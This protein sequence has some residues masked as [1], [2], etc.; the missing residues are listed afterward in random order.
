MIFFLL[1]KW[2]KN[3]HMLPQSNQ[4]LIIRSKNLHLQL[5]TLLFNTSPFPPHKSVQTVRS[6]KDQTRGLFACCSSCPYTKKNS[7]NFLFFYLFYIHLPVC[8]YIFFFFGQIRLMI[9]LWR[10]LLSSWHSSF[11]SVYAQHLLGAFFVFNFCY[12]SRWFM[13]ECFWMW[14]EKGMCCLLDTKKVEFLRIFC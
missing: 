9:I 10:C 8:A 4:F 3:W 5:L 1:K 2:H 14:M 11:W 6:E 12:S 7:W 13:D